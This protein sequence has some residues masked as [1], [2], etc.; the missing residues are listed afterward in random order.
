VFVPDNWNHAIVGG[1]VLDLAATKLSTEL[2]S[3]GVNV[4][5]TRARSVVGLIYDAL[6]KD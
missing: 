6:F 4:S 5:N 1:L 2:N 3:R